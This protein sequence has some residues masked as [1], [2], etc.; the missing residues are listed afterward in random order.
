M[1]FIQAF[2]CQSIDVDVSLLFIGS[3]NRIGNQMFGAVTAQAFLFKELTL[4]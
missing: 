3:A 1:V 4:S 2:C